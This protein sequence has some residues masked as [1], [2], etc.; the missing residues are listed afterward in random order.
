M[1]HDELKK[2]ALDAIEKVFGD[3]S[4]G[5]QTTIDSL[6]EIMDNCNDY[7]MSIETDL[8]HQDEIADEDDD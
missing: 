2:Q 1:T 7:I 5:Q 6:R 4:V 8:S 3:T